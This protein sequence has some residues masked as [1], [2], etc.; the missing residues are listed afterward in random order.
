MNTYSALLTASILVGSG[1]TLA[2]RTM[3]TAGSVSKVETAKPGRTRHHVGKAAMHKA[4]AKTGTHAKTPA[5][6]SAVSA[7]HDPDLPW[8]LPT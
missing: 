7:L 2:A 4:S 8:V 6:A 3:E 5:A 1:V